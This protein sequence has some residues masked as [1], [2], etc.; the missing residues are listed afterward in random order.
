MAPEVIVSCTYDG[1]ADIWSTGIT[2][3]ELALGSPPYSDSIYP[4]QVIYLI[5][6]NPPPRLEGYQFS[7]EFKD[8]IAQCLVKDAKSR[9]TAE[10][11]LQHSF[12]RKLKIKREKLLTTNTSEKSKDC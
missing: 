2:A 8:F 6:S 10:T 12:F 1:C 4:H 11:L 7:A 9:P 5:P 3:I